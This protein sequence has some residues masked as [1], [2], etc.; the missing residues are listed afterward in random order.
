MVLGPKMIKSRIAVF[1]T[2]NVLVVIALLPSL[3][4]TPIADSFGLLAN[5][6]RFNS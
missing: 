6:P 2:L 1:D 5:T 3:N 4:Q